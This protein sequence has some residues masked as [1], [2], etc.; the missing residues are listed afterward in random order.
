MRAKYPQFL[1]SKP[2]FWGLNLLD[3]FI[4]GGGLLFSLNFHL[5][6]ILCLILVLAVIVARKLFG[7]FFDPVGFILGL[8]RNLS[9]LATGMSKRGKR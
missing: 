2:T 8:L 6:S 9:H 4:I 5:N 3:L 7:K 1:N